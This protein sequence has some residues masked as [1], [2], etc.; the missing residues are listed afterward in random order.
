MTAKQ[1]LFV[2]EYLV[3]L[4]ATAAA[5]R[6]GYADS[7]AEKQ[8]SLW[9]PGLGKSRDAC[10]ENYRSVWDAI[11]RA[12]AERRERVEIE[13]DTVLRELL[14]LAT[15]NV[16][17]YTVDDD[18]RIELVDGAPE[19]AVGAVSSVKITRTPKPGMGD[20]IKTEYRLWDKNSA[21][22]KLAKHLGLYEQDNRQKTP[23]V[24]RWVLRT[25]NHDTDDD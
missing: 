2:E 16:N 20:E 18:G 12:K 3:D 17:H 21:L 7:T 25:A 5:K 23:D 19:N 8:A 22:D 15:S 11:E 4:N 10:P 24:I 6:A 13:A 9:V 14:I 1:A